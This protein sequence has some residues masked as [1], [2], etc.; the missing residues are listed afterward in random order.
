MLYRF[1]VL[2]KDSKYRYCIDSLKLNERNDFR[3]VPDTLN[4]R[5]YRPARR[6]YNILGF[7]REQ[8]IFV[9]Q[10]F[11][12]QSGQDSTYLSSWFFCYIVI[13]LEWKCPI[14][15]STSDGRVTH[16]SQMA[17]TSCLF[18]R[19]RFTFMRERRMYQPS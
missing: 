1:F 7:R 8:K 16:G 13:F 15:V 6:C 2:K 4:G 11:L 17:V 10:D 19:H 9:C 5:M 12:R 3:L 14:D 18:R